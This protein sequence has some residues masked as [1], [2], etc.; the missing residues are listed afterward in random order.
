MSKGSHWQSLMLDRNRKL[1]S[2]RILPA[3]LALAGVSMTVLSI[4]FLIN[5]A[6]L[7]IFMHEMLGVMGVIFVNSV[8]L[9]VVAIYILAGKDNDATAG[10]KVVLLVLCLFTAIGLAIA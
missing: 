1:D 10:D 9:S 4:M 7:G 2:E 6:R 8:I 5:A 3:A